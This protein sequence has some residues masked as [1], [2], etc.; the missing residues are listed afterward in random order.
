MTSITSGPPIA[1]PTT[2]IPVHSDVT[3]KLAF[4][5]VQAGPGTKSGT[6][7]FNLNIRNF[8]TVACQHIK[9]AIFHLKVLKIKTCLKLKAK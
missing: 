5:A 2:G 7:K 6:N 4:G 8:P 3:V 9:F 1:T